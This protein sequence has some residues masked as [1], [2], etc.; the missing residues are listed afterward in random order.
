V[1]QHRIEWRDLERHIRPRQRRKYFCHRRWP[2]G[3]RWDQWR[4]KWS[5]G[6][7]IQVQSRG[8]WKC[9]Q[10][11]REC[12]H[13]LAHQRRLNYCGSPGRRQ[14]RH[15]PAKGAVTLRGSLTGTNAS[16]SSGQPDQVVLTAG[17]A[18]AL[19]NGAEATSDTFGA[20][21]CGSIQVTAQGRLTMTS[22]ATRIGALTT[23][24]V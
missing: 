7:I 3:D 5:A 1:H 12:R 4:R 17:G 15:G 2:A 9:W 10:R 24:T 19:S 14:R 18:I 13:A 20:G 22:P 11:A 21:D 8:S 23:R 6:N 16:A